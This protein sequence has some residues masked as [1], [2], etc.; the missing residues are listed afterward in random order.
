MIE[1]GRPAS[2]A[3]GWD[4][5]GCSD[6]SW[7][8]SPGLFNIGWQEILLIVLF[9]LGL[10]VIP[11]PGKWMRRVKR[12]PLRWS[13]QFRAAPIPTIHEAAEAFLCSYASGEYSLEGRE[14]FRLTF[15]RGPMPRED[16]Q[17]VLSLRGDPSSDELPVL[18]R[19]LFQPKADGLTVTFK[20]EVHAGK[21]LPTGLRKKLESSLRREIKDFRA[22]LNESF[23]SPDS[24][25]E[26][27][28]RRAKQIDVI[29][30][31]DAGE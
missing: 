18:L 11:L 14:R 15:R 8:L 22:Y 26:A 13:F 7:R 29:R 25:A 27:P 31:D 17:V 2:G 12:E 20:Y 16:G 1:H 3:G 6:G 30:H 23:G 21:S 5:V 19:V 4:V 9:L 28:R 10:V 24:I